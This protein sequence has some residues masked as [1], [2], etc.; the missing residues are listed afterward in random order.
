MLLIFTLLL[1]T[2]FICLPLLLGKF[3]SFLTLLLLK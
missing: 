1:T 3:F 2:G